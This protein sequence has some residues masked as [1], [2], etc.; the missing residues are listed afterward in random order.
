MCD[1]SRSVLDLLE[2]T[3]SIKHLMLN[4]VFFRDIKR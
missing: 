4:L 1:S 3:I 2:G